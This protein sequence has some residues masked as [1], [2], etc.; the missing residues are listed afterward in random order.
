MFVHNLDHLVCDDVAFMSETDSR[1]LNLTGNVRGKQTHLHSRFIYNYFTALGVK[2]WGF[3]SF[4]SCCLELPF[5][6]VRLR[7]K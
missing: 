1:R 4:L 7:V 6:L 2:T 5:T 3:G